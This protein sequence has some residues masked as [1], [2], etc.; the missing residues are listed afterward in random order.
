MT[1]IPVVDYEP[2]AGPPARTASPQCRP[3]PRSPHRPA[4]PEAAPAVAQPEAFGARHR[5]A[6][7]FAE[8]ALRAVLE[9][10]DGRR[11]PAQLDAVL[12]G[13]LADSVVGLRRRNR[14]QDAAMLRRVRLQAADRDACTFEV[15]ASY[16]RGGRV[17]AIAARVGPDPSA[18][19]DWRLTALHIG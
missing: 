9:V 6:A 10:I 5:S 7:A 19:R 13:L 1:V 18:R 15:A 8:T 17:H 11:H 3:I 12:G 4:P 14:C 2:P 16:L